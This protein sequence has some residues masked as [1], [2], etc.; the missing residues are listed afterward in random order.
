[1][2]S[3]TC[4]MQR[5]GG[6]MQRAELPTIAAFPSRLDR[7][8]R[9]R[10]DPDWLAT[11][12]Q[13]PNTLVL[14]VDAGR[15]PIRE[16]HGLADQRP[17]SADL[18]LHL[19]PPQGDLPGDAVYLGETD[20]AE[21]PHAERND[22]NG[23]HLLA[24]PAPGEADGSTP[25]ATGQAFPW[26]DLRSVGSLLPAAESEVLAQATA[27]LAW[28]ATSGFCPACG[29]V[30][31]VC[32]SGWMRTCT[33]CGTLHFPRTDPAVITAVIDPQDRL[34]LGSAVHW[35]VRRYSTF[36]GFVEAGE[37]VE[38]AVAREV[39]EEA[40]VVVD[41]V[42]YFSS[43]AWPFPRSLMLGF[44]GRTRD[45]RAAA[46]QDEIRDVRW[47]SRSELHAAVS[48]GA[49]RI[50][51]RSSISRAL[52]DHWYG[53]HLPDGGPAPRG[54]SLQNGPVFTGPASSPGAS[55]R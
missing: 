15:V 8:S 6:P 2:K 37:S 12:W 16:D 14:R 10:Q 13:Q 32:S 45:S 35:E 5:Y 29:G 55:L 17:G 9:D 50:P 22:G 18:H 48:S 7:R 3:Q 34:L 36:A 28:H 11:L 4:T 46:D 40:G 53:G 33:S 19:H 54:P 44:L 30:T 26:E 39:E 51:P 43:Q 23:Y 27:V 20:Q 49:I 52:I 47:F 38:H 25:T 21:P 24:V 1:M 41:Q 42:E 31:T